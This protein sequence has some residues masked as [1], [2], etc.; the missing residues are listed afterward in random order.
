[1]DGFSFG[2]NVLKIGQRV[3]FEKFV[4]FG[5]YQR[6][7]LE[8]GSFTPF[9]V[10]EEFYEKYRSQFAASKLVVIAHGDRILD[11]SPREDFVTLAFEDRLAHPDFTAPILRV[12]A[13][14][15]VGV[16]CWS[17]DR[18]CS[19]KHY[20][21]SK[22]L[23]M[24]LYDKPVNQQFEVIRRN[25]L[26]RRTKARRRLESVLESFRCADWQANIS[27]KKPAASVQEALMEARAASYRSHLMAQDAR[28]PLAE[29]ATVRSWLPSRRL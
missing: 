10:D 21:S 20:G 26:R 18:P 22:Y 23:D 29:R 2:R 25:A 1:M 11:R 14:Q 24:E 13:D 27:L 15:Q 4:L 7:G 8:A 5:A 9:A 28:R 12:S 3:T 17:S 16:N 19:I 6:S